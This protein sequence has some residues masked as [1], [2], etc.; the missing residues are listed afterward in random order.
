LRVDILF[1]AFGTAMPS[2]KHL[3]KKSPQTSVERWVKHPGP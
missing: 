1:N 2:T 3:F